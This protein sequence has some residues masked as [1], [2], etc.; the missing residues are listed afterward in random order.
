MNH[1]NDILTYKIQA[2][3]AH[4]TIRLAIDNFPSHAYPSIQDLSFRSACYA[5]DVALRVYFADVKRLVHNEVTSLLQPL[6]SDDDRTIKQEARDRSEA[7]SKWEDEEYP[8]SYS[9]GVLNNLIHAVSEP[10][11]GKFTLTAAAIGPKPI[12]FFADAIINQC[13]RED[14]RRH[15]PFIAGGNF[16]PVARVALS[17]MRSF[18]LRDHLPASDAK[19]FIFDAF[20]TAAGTL[21]INHIPWI[22]NP[23]G[24]FGRPSSSIVHD[25]WLNLGAKPPP[26]LAC[27]HSFVSRQPSTSTLAYYASEEIQAAD[28]RAEWSALDPSLNNFKDVL[29]KVSL[30]VEWDINHATCDG[31]PAYITEAYQYVQRIYN[32]SEPLHQLAMICAIICAGLLPRIFSPPFQGRPESVNKFPRY[33]AGLKWVIKKNHKG[34]SQPNPFITMVS[35]FIICHFDTKSPIHSQSNLRAWFKKHSES[36]CAL[37]FY[38][39]DLF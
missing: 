23:N 28:P 30:P 21:K 5:A 4:F 37:M 19:R 38:T 6:L 12:S 25:V 34:V 26:S 29:H 32:A 1:T 10:R 31:G 24:N 35:T 36:S 3:E 13:T 18:A 9:H 8:L 11:D 2:Y 15:P 7:L 27:T 33:I 39:N 17:E 14:N 16:L 20:C 22:T